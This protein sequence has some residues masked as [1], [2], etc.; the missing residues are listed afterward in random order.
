VV[1]VKYDWDDDKYILNFEQHGIRFEIA[2]GVFAD[3]NALEVYDKVHSSLTEKRF[4][5]I[6]MSEAGVLFVV[7]CERNAENEEVIRIISARKATKMEKAGYE[8]GI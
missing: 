2:Q 5:I 4:N 1:K 7:F 8:R 3:E 6:G